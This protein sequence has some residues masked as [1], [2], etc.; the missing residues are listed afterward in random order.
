MPKV[1]DYRSG[2]ASLR[3]MSEPDDASSPAREPGRPL[4]G[5]FHLVLGALASGLGWFILDQATERAARVL[6]WFFLLPG[7]GFLFVG[8][9]AIGA[10]IALDAYDYD[11]RRRR[12]G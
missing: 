5:G 7:L 2:P 4:A 8:L 10:G 9:V 12:D 11:R 3:A 1:S 6:G